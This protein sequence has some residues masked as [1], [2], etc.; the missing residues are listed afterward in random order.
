MAASSDEPCL[1]AAGVNPD[2]WTKVLALD[3]LLKK[4]SYP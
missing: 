3:D 2:R 4:A 1:E